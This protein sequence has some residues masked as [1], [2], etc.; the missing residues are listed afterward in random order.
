MRYF[1]FIF[2]GTASVYCV[3]FRWYPWKGWNYAFPSISAQIQLKQ[4]NEI[5]KTKLA[6]MTGVY[7]DLRFEMEKMQS[8]GSAGEEM[9]GRSLASIAPSSLKFSPKRKHNSTDIADFVQQ[10]TYQWNS[11]KLLTYFHK[12]W[13]LKQYLEAAQFGLT[14]FFQPGGAKNFKEIDLFQL[15]VASIEGQVYLDEGL[16]VLTNYI[17][18]YPKSRYYIRAKLWM[19][20]AQ[21]KLGHVSEFHTSL[22]EFKDKY[23]NTQ[24]WDILSNLYQ[25][26]GVSL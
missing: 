25:K 21:Y 24:E 9:S 6:H 20:L 4:E 16:Q 23:R 2:L 17:T 26:S 14:L 19:A 7:E 1:L 3:T 12:H 10:D 18:H 22:Q 13:N 8:K 11:E 15:G 5:L